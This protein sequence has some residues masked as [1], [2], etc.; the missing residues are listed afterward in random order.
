MADA[1]K[2][3]APDPK[4]AVVDPNSADT[5]ATDAARSASVA[6]LTADHAV[7]VNTMMVDHSA[8]IEAL[9]TQHES[10]MAKLRADLD[11]ANGQIAD[12]KAKMTGGPVRKPD[13]NGNVEV[14]V[15]QPLHID[16]APYLDPNA[17]GLSAEEAASRRD[18]QNTALPASVD[19]VTGLNV[20]PSW[21][22]DHWLVKAMA[23]EDVPAVK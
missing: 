22:A 23:V 21:V 19:L 6:S 2:T 9:N 17:P 18:A 11:T 10:E 12:L 5:A 3:D 1:P 15:K 8:E 16:P 14:R 4:G 13:K 20:V 7:A